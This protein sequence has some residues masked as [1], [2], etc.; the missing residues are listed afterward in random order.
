MNIESIINKISL[1]QELV[2]E[3]GFK[4]DIGDYFQAI[5][6]SQNQN[7]VFMKDLSQKTK[8]YLEILEN[9]SLDAEL[10]IVL[11]K[12]ESFTSLK[13]IEKLVELD[14]DSQI[15]AATYYQNFYAILNLLIKAINENESE[16][17][18]VNITFSKYVSKEENKLSIEELA[19]VSLVFKDLQST[20]N[21]KEFAKVLHLWNRTLLIYH[22]LLKSESPDE[23]TL[24]EIQ[25]GSID[26]IFNIDITFIEQKLSDTEIVQPGTGF[27][28]F[29]FKTKTVPEE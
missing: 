18:E 14:I 16:L 2:I 23:I 4:R 26:V 11:K 8:A 3:S 1:F 25:N 19:I 28:S 13:T 7:L 22:T 21:L 10:K 20:G 24:V 5:N 17:V 27:I 29:M 15:D 12:S 6:Q 9:N